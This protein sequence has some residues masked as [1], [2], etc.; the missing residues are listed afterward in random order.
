[1]PIYAKIPGL[2]SIPTSFADGAPF[3]IYSCPWAHPLLIPSYFSLASVVVLILQALFSLGLVKRLWLRA[4]IGAAVENESEGVSAGESCL[5][6]TGGS[7]DSART[8]L[9]SSQVDRPYSFSTSRASASR[10]S[11]SSGKKKGNS[12]SRSSR[13]PSIPPACCECTHCAA[14]ANTDALAKAKA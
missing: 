10:H 2:L 14:P 9:V 4:P 11:S 13:P 7:S 3:I 1:V 12:R 5:V 6:C 8:G